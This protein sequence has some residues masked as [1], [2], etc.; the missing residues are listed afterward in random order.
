MIKIDANFLATYSREEWF[1][2]SNFYYKMALGELPMSKKYQLHKDLVVQVL[3]Q[4]T[5]EE[6]E[7]A[8]EVFKECIKIDLTKYSK[9][10]LLDMLVAP[11]E[12]EHKGHPNIYFFKSKLKELFLM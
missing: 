11:L 3:L 8:L 1:F 5:E 2:L 10:E 7:I 4:A 12:K 6:L 9:Y